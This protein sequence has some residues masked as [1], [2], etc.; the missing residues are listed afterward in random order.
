MCVLCQS[1]PLVDW[2]ALDGSE[3]EPAQI[4]TA[5]GGTSNGTSIA[6]NQNL[7]NQL[8]SS[9]VWRTSG[10]A[11]ASTISYGFTTSNSFASAFGE[12]RPP[13]CFP[14]ACRKCIA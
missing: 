14:P 3:M 6:I 12:G 8:D 7:V 5:E 13:A 2:H 4:G 10:N 9:A 1:N 11:V